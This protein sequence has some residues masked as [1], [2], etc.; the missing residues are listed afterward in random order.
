MLDIN[1]TNENDEINLREIFFNLWGHKFFIACTCIIGIVYGGYVSLNTQKKYTSTAI[2]KLNVKQYNMPSLPSNI[3]ALAKIANISDA[4]KPLSKDEILG[5]EFILKIDK[6]VDLTKD[7]Y[8][9]SI[10]TTTK[11]PKWKTFI[12]GFIGLESLEANYDEL[13]MQQV[14][15]KYKSNV[16]FEIT[17]DNSILLSVVH[18]DP[19]RSA[20]IS[21]SIM[22]TI[23]NT[24]KMELEDE[25]NNQLSYLSQTLAVSLDDL[26]TAQQKLNTFTLK[27]KSLP[28]ED[29]MSKTQ[30]LD[31][32]RSQLTRASEIHIALS[33]LLSLIEKGETNNSDYLLLRNKFPVVDQLEFRRVLGQ[34]EVITVWAWPSKYLVEG[35]L[36]TITER[37][38]RLE[39]NVIKAKSQAERAS[40]DLETY[41]GLQRDVKISEAA[42]AVLIETVKAQSMASGYKADNAKIYEYA[43]APTSPSSP[44]RKLII[45][46]HSLLGLVVGSI[47]AMLYAYSR[48]TYY[49]KASLIYE[50]KAS[51]YDKTHNLLPLR[52][53]P[54]EKISSRISLKSKQTLRLFALEINRYTGH[55]VLVTS[56]NSRL[57]GYE[58]SKMIASYMNSENLT[59]A[60]ID[61]NTKNSYSIPLIEKN[62]DDLFTVFEMNSDISIIKPKTAFET[63]DFVGRRDFHEHLKSINSK[64]DLVF[65]FADDDD[66]ISLSSALVNQNI[67]HIS[68]VRIKRTKSDD[69]T[70][71]RNL[72]P[73]QGLL[74]E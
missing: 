14:I 50:S 25:I 52:K 74:Y 40:Q 44:N 51:L 3:S 57:N 19:K 48:G 53:L 29:F 30:N 72:V 10:N 41:T 6:I 69:L 56:L 67:C 61:F 55:N 33:E 66:A 8:F 34:N 35:V 39:A 47:I 26:E 18:T 62:S 20:I 45:M 65:L 17:Q 2:F 11:E 59:I 12:K 4:P 68:A 9:N 73:I 28:L 24:K 23:I 43:I 36:D 31:S 38:S 13:V 63:I 37:K 64:Y 27:N 46:L 71:L 42:Y 22:N 60:L 70:K 21:N 58:I 32:L 5:R 1:R 16:S 7:S 15:R 49:S 54:I